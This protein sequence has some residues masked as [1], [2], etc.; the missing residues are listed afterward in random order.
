MSARIVF[1]SSQN[2]RLQ[3]WLESHPDGH[4]RAAFVL[5]RKLD[6]EVTGLTASPRFVCID[7][8]VRCTVNS[9]HTCF[10]QP[11]PFC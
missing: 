5:F 4:E 7:I 6:R 3:E 8:V 9:G 10:K 1:T 2:V 11:V